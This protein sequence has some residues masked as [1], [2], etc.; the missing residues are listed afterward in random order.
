MDFEKTWRSWPHPKPAL[1]GG[2]SLPHSSLDTVIIEKT[3]GGGVKTQAV[4]C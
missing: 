1:D 2:L 3:L 4:E